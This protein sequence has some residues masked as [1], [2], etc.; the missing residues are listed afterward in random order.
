MK[1]NLNE[2]A[3]GKVGRT[4]KSDAETFVKNNPEVIKQFKNI[5]KKVGGKAVAAQILNL[6]LFGKPSEQPKAKYKLVPQVS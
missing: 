5:V 2:S 1:L 4:G 3:V 6:N